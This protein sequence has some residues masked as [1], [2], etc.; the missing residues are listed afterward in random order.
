MEFYGE[1]MGG[2]VER[3]D[4][5]GVLV[6]LQ[7]QNGRIQTEQT[8]KNVENYLLGK[9]NEMNAYQQCLASYWMSKYRQNAFRD[10]VLDQIKEKVEGIED[11]MLKAEAAIMF[12][13]SQ[14][15]DRPN[16]NQQFPLSPL[17]PTHIKG[18]HYYREAK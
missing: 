16:P 12:S 9:K 13:Y 5:G 15:I 7:E 2:L 1:I 14:L 6:F 11:S 8:L 3:D 10:S 17:L 4:V 18:N